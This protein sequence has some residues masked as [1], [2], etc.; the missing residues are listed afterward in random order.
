M[1]AADRDPAT[2]ARLALACL[3]LT[4]LDAAASRADITALCQAANGPAGRTAAVCVLPMHVAT[5]RAA[6]G[7]SA[8]EMPR[9]ATT[10]NF[11]AGTD[12]VE[13][14]AADIRAALAAGADEID[15]VLPW[16]ALLAGDAATV[17][18]VLA[19]ARAATPRPRVLKVILETGAL[20]DPAMI[21][22]AARLAL[23]AGAD[24]LKTST[25]KGPP[26]A[27][28]EAVAQM[29]DAIVDTGSTAGIKVSGGVRALADVATY[30]AIVG[31]R[32]GPAS[33]APTRLRIG[34]SAL[35]GAITAV[36][37][38]DTHAGV[39]AGG[40]LRPGY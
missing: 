1:H 7:P 35:L 9:I 10:A 2:T 27:T 3:D 14:I 28:P 16:R 8:P 38:Q 15:V 33:L 21:D 20:G 34:A 12:G 25:G 40:T 36:L 26:G 30:A 19:A 17:T 22:R 29:A 11:P 6:L 13:T 23:A 37:G 32:L 4:L 39:D 18:G 24:F 5:A 31:A